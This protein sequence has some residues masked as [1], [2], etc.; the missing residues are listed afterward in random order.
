MSDRELII[1][2]QNELRQHNYNYYVLDTP[3]IS[4]F[5]FDTKLKQLQILELQYPELQTSSSPTQRVGGEV[6]KIL[7]QLNMSKGCIH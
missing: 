3:T 2:L 4:D 6:T 1:Q 7:I 5:D